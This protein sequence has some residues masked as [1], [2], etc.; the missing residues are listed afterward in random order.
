MAARLVQGGNGTVGTGGEG[1][2][3]EI[4]ATVS[5]RERESVQSPGEIT[6]A[7]LEELRYAEEC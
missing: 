2:E 4:S 1:N 7:L 3:A 6:A 5:E